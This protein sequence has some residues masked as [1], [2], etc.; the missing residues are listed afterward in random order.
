ML[1]A[2]ASLQTA[3]GDIR[4]ELPGPLNLGCFDTLFPWPMPLV[5]EHFARHHP[6]VGTILHEASSDGL[7][8]L[9]Q[10]GQPDAAFMYR[11]HASVPLESTTISGM[12][13][14]LVLPAGRRLP[15]Q[16]QVEVPQRRNHPGRRRAGPGVFGHHGQAAG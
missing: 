16:H 5:L 15:R 1:G 14:Q 3:A 8:A 12:R 9:L 10:G 6:R 13:L 11:L 2:A 7:Q 4:G